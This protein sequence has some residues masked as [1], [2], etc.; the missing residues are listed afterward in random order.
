MWIA[1]ALAGLLTL[2]QLRYGRFGA[3]V[4]GVCFLAA[5][6][7]LA[8]VVFQSSFVWC[9]PVLPLAMIACGTLF[10]FVWPCPRSDPDAARE[11]PVY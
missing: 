10:C 6:M 1:T 5:L 8:M 7:A 4:S 9:P 3:L 2:W 11:T